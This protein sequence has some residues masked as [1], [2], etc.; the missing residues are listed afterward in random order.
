MVII[1]IVLGIFN[2]Q[3]LR[4]W[5]SG[6]SLNTLINVVSQ[7]AQTA[8]FVPVAASISQMKW[9]WYS[10][11]KPVEEIEDFDK[12]SRGPMDSLWL[13]TKHPKW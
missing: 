13:I 5:H 2:D 4:S 1:F 3:P 11:S 9:I 6:L 10:K 7:I 8:V 12:A